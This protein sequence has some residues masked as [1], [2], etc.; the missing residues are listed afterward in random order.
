MGV[1]SEFRY[2]LPNYEIYEI[3]MKQ[4]YLKSSFREKLI[5]HLFVGE[6]LKHSWR[7]GVCSLE[8]SK[9]EVDNQGYDLI[10]ET[11]GIIRHIQLKAAHLQAKTAKQNVHIALAGKPS[12]CVIWIYINKETLELGPY[13]FFGDSPGEPL[14]D[15]NSFKVARHT[16]RDAK[17]IKLER[18]EIRV[19]PKNE[20]RRLESIGEVFDVLFSKR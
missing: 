13:L 7:S 5:E 9:P 14:P 15:M 19:V 4:H 1:I 16:K 18:P 17:G 10:A 3:E 2:T 8:I 11:N 20:F 12:G 6:L